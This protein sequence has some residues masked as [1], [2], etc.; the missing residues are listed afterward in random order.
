MKQADNG[1]S[2]A[3]GGGRC[4]RRGS[5]WLLVPAL[6]LAGGGQA[7]E[8]LYSK[9][10]SPLTG[11]LGLPSP[12]A[13]ALTPPGDWQ[14]ALHGAG[15]SHFVLD[16]AG[17]EQ[18]RL[19]GESYR[20]A[21]E[22]R[23]GVGGG[24]ELQLELPWLAHNG[25]SMDSLI[26]GWHDLWGMSDGGRGGVPRDQLDFVY[27]APGAGFTLRDSAAGVGDLT[28]ALN[29]ALLAGPS[30]KVSAELGYKFA[31]G[32]ERELLGSGAEDVHVA[33]RAAGAPPASRFSW[34]GQAG[35]LR[36]GRSSVLG[37]RQR[38][39]L[40]FAGVGLSWAA[41]DQLALIAQLDA[42]GAPL[43][44][45]LPV[46]GGSALRLTA[47]GRWQVSRQWALELSIVE[48]VRVETAPDIIFQ[49]SARWHL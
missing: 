13:A 26:D 14:L 48:D 15:A 2:W 9:N 36:A 47:G 18:V 41:T 49:A 20:L 21:L 44:S 4:R 29:R 35:Y 19:D 3:G 30:L 42:H 1:V 16:E 10:L 25:G 6:L 17:G 8:P 5:W 37:E 32:S 23:R 12:R 22:L 45:A 28:L 40:W 43:R 27:R 7:T 33:L 24:W 38:R 31:T 11:L 34:Q 46:V 39:D